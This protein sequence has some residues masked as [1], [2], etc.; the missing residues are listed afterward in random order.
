MFELSNEHVAEAY[1]PEEMDDYTKY[2]S[3]VLAANV[4][5]LVYTGEFDMQ[6][7][8]VTQVEWMH[9]IVMNDAMYWKRA[10]HIYYI[11][12]AKGKEIV[13]GYYRDSPA[14]PFTFLTVPKAGH[15]VPTTYL[16]ATMQFLKDYITN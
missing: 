4:P 5:T 9:N 13:G 7:G 2:Y 12:N 15:F 16:V 6:D 1:D 14:V 11:K 3:E 10:R 8:P